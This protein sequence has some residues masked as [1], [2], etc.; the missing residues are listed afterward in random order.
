MFDDPE[1][2]DASPR[3]TWTVRYRTPLAILTAVL[4]ALC[5]IALFNGEAVLMWIG[6]GGLVLLIA[7][8]VLFQAFY[9]RGY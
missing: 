3:R 9:R 6:A 2:T 5:F 8:V 7:W 4:A 1:Q